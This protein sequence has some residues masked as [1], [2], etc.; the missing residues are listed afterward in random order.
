VKRAVF[1]TVVCVIAQAQ[2]ASSGISVPVT[3]GGDVLYGNLQNSYAGASAAAG[4][5]VGLSPAVRL[6]DH[7]FVYSALEVRSSSYFAY[8]SGPDTDQ[9]VRF[10][11]MQAFLGY[12]RTIKKAS[13][14]VKAGRLNSAFGSFP[15]Q[16]DDAKTSFPNP[17]P[18]YITNLPLRPDQL[19]C[20][21]KSLLYQQPGADID[22]YCG[23]SESEAYG[24]V[25]VTLYGL[26]GAE[27]DLSL[28]RIDARLQLTN[29]SPVNPQG[30]ASSSQSAQWAAGGGYTFGSGLHVGLSGFHGP[31]LDR[32]V[33]PW[34]HSATIANFPATGFGTDL[35]WARAR[36]SVNGEWQ[37]FRFT[38][39]GFRISPS[40]QIA[41]GELKSILTPRMFLAVRATG[42]SFAPGQPQQ[43]YEFG[44]G[45]RPNN[46]Q[47]LKLAYARVLPRGNGLELQL[48]TTVT[49][50][51]RAFRSSTPASP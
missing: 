23:G 8:D 12:N 31:Y 3:I 34:L 2:E 16:Y 37:R 30:L 11:L 21:A 38:L 5:R 43:V 17:P 46:H 26:P 15:P 13:I 51:A 49:A 6:G 35:Q 20:G 32:V 7:W 24:M 27:V 29:S 40:E 47:L 25:P 22:F 1:L 50:F 39:P 41:Y 4:F 33:Q 36:W 44:F 42:L 18:S 9:E 10:K 48:V 19:P 28:A 45:F 14:L